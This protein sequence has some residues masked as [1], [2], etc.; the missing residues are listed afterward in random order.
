VSHRT[1]Q[2]TADAR[3]LTGAFFRERRLG[4]SFGS[5]APKTP[6]PE[7]RRP[8]Y[9]ARM[10]ALAHHIQRAIDEGR[11]ADRTTMAGHL[12]VTRA[13]VTQLLDLLLLAPDLQDAILGLEAVD[14]VEPL[15]E[16]VLR[17]LCHVSSWVEQ[18]ALWYELTLAR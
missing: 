11:V 16:R 7:V 3:V 5:V 2:P 14:G 6:L 8:A 18:R 15:S 1:G 10:V 12:F 13:R 9:I 17:P 4:V